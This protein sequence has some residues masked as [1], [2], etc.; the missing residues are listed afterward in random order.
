MKCKD[1]DSCYRGKRFLINQPLIHGIN[2]STIVTLELADFLQK[3]GAIVDVFT[4]TLE[5]PAKS[6]FLKRGLKVSTVQDNPKYKLENY[7]Y[8]WVNSQVL[9]PS[10]IDDLGKKHPKYPAFIFLHMSSMDWIPD[11]HPYIHLLEEKLSSLSLYICEE[12]RK[13]N[14]GYF[15]TEPTYDYFRN[16]A[17]DDFLQINAN[18][19]KEELQKVLLVSNYAPKELNEACQL[20]TKEKIAVETLGEGCD[21]YEL[22]TPNIL[23]QYDAVITIAKTVQ[24][25]LV[26]NTPVYVYGK[27]GGA[28]WLNKDNYNKAKHTNFCGSE[29]FAKKSSKTI[30]SEIQA[31]FA[32]GKAFQNDNLKAFQNEF[33][34]KETLPILLL[35]AKS[36]SLN[37]F[38]SQYLEML[39]SAA[40]FERIRFEEWSNVWRL[41]NELREIRSSRAFKALSLASRI[42]RKYLSRKD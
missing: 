34:L 16:P 3:N 27:F 9:P 12:V 13:S 21:K 33:S 14:I 29:G 42:R 18:N 1:S 8:I 17:P 26:S 2:G 25:C 24:Y 4:L 11:E 30:A 5:K 32:K 19:S 37:A 15:Y 6:L 41:T 10:I 20:L 28:G 36:K 39:K 23:K 35:K 40:Y 7:D 38:D 31:G 22:L